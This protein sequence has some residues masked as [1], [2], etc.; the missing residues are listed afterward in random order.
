MKL[1]IVYVLTHD[2]IFIGEDGPTHQ[3]VETLNALRVIPGVQV[4]RPGDAEETNEAWKMA[5]ESKDHPVCL[6]LT[7]QGLPVYEKDDPDWKHT[8]RAG[9]YIVKR[10]AS[11]ASGL[12]ITILATGSEVSMA[13]E[14][15]AKITD[16]K[17]RVVS[18]MDRE[19]FRKQPS[20]LRSEI[21][22]S[23]SRVV[24]VEAG[25]AMG[26][27]EFA[28]ASKDIFAVN[29]FGASGPGDKVASALG[30]TVENLVKLLN[31]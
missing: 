26:W 10:G 20:V 28:T 9:A 14:A 4:L 8:I 13:L 29:R 2:S 23:P 12:D 6:A 3:P 15:A 31:E 19:L 30:F 18:V 22:G 11:D 1:N 5:I 24:T 7:R 17:I 16:K 25:S 27:E 21:M